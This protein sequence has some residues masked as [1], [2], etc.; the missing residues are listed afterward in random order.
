MNILV[1]I[2]PLS[3]KGEKQFYEL[4]IHVAAVILKLQAV[5]NVLLL[6]ENKFKGKAFF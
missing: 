1:W 6:F 2:H 3:I 4:F 5:Q